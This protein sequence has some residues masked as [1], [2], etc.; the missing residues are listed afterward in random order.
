MNYPM[1]GPKGPGMP[2]LLGP[3]GPGGP[4]GM[5]PKIMVT[6]WQLVDLV[7]TCGHPKLIAWLDLRVSNYQYWPELCS[8]LRGVF[9]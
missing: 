4:C 8:V 7:A 3:C 9:I 1:P 6:W 2:G 5:R